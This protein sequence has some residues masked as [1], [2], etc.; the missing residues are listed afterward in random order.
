MFSLPTV[1]NILSWYTSKAK[2]EFR[3]VLNLGSG[4]CHQNMAVKIQSPDPG[5]WP[6][7]AL[8]HIWVCLVLCVCVWTSQAALPSSVH[9]RRGPVLAT[10]RAWW[11]THWWCVGSGTLG[12]RILWSWV[13]CTWSRSGGGR[14]G[15][16]ASL[17]IGV[18]HVVLWTPV[19]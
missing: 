12:Q 18:C 6:S 11:F 16:C 19:L 5:L 10:S 2:L 15:R 9:N 1:R 14:G 17:E 4:F 8:P 7:S 3:F 13:P